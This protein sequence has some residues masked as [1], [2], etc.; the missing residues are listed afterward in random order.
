L[1][2]NVAEARGDKSSYF[3]I[4]PIVGRLSGTST[5]NNS[6]TQE[7]FKYDYANILYGGSVGYKRNRFAFRIKA[8]KGDL[9]YKGKSPEIVQGITQKFSRHDL[10]LG[11]GLDL[12]WHFELHLEYLIRSNLK[13]AAVESTESAEFLGRGYS[14]GLSF[15]RIPLLKIG[16]EMRNIKYSIANKATLLNPI[17]SSELFLYVGIPLKF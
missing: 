14:V 10:T 4:T 5:Q 15:N 12:F 6:I 13:R 17:K 11:I 9:E 16:L 8:L 7:D 1:S 3:E 2:S